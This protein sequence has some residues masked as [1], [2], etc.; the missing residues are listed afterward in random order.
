[1][2]GNV[3]DGRILS[4]EW[5][6]PVG[7]ANAGT[8][9]TV[10]VPVNEAPL[11][12]GLYGIRFVRSSDQNPDASLYFVSSN[13]TNSIGLLGRVQACSVANG[14]SSGN[15]TGTDDNGGDDNGGDDNG[16]DDNGGDD[17]GGDDNGGDDNGGDD[18]G[19]D[20]NSGDD[21]G[22]ED[23]SGDNN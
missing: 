2:V 16:G 21:N 19:G 9:A 22:G 4:Y 10:G 7:G 8:P 14:T 13:G 20:D 18:N 6:G 17:N 3:G 12:P 1:L 23:D 15:S 11:Y 5:P